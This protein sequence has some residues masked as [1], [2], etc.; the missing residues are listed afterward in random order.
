[1]L[2]LFFSFV[3]LILIY[4]VLTSFFFSDRFVDL[5]QNP[6]NALLKVSICVMSSSIVLFLVSSR[7]LSITV[8]V[9]SFLLA[10]W[11]QGRCCIWEWTHQV[12]TLVDR[13]IVFLSSLCYSSLIHVFFIN[14][15]FISL[16]GVLPNRIIQ[17]IAEH[18]DYPVERLGKMFFRFGW[19]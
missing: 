1:M 18:S 6:V 16:V 3:G 10:W 15:F 17:P 7:N 13:G 19:Y 8:L 4:F 9:L 14:V 5:S 11:R 2:P 12:R